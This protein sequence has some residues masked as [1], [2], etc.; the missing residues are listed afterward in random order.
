M[1]RYQRENLTPRHSS[2]QKKASVMLQ[3]HVITIDGA[4]VGAALRL[5]ADYRFIAVDIRMDDL[6]G[7]IWPS[8][9]DVQRLAHRLYRTGRLD[10]P[11][12]LP[13]AI[14][15]Q[16]P[17]RTPWPVVPPAAGDA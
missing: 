5:D 4:F 15:A 10:D 6:D 9:A 16:P 13:T 12:R 11:S 7:T 2:P 14:S 17:P 3:S 8:L 1:S